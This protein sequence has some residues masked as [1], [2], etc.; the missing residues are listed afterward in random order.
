VINRDVAIDQR[1]SPETRDCR[2]EFVVGQN[3]HVLS[4][5]ARALF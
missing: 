4:G 2:A 3:F 5:V 1:R